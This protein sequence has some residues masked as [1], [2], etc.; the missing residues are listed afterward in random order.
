MHGKDA[1]LEEILDWRPYD[2]VT[3][4]AAIPTPGGLLTMLH[5]TELEPTP[6]GTTLHYRYAA[7]RTKREL[8]IAKQVAPAYSEGLLA[9]R[10]ELV[11]RIEA[12]MAGD[13]ELAPEP[14]L[15]RPKPDGPLASLAALGPIRLID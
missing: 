4:R 11:A 3:V 15:T 14:E 10:Q 2:Y 1:V 13:A 9:S 5:T 12:A 7:P 8:E 6:T